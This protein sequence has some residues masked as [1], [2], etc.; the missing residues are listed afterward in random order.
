MERLL[1]YVWQHRLYP[2]G[3]LTTTAGQ[4]VEVL[5]PG[6]HNTDA[7]PDFLQAQ[8]RIG[9]VL[10]AGNVEIHLKSSDW[11][12]HRHES[13]PAYNNVV[14]HVVSQADRE[15]KTS[16]GM[17]LPQMIV[18]VPDYVKQ[19][20]EEL[21][22][23]ETFP[24]CYR[25]ATALPRLC[26]HSWLDALCT[27]RL[28]QKTERLLLLLKR[29]GG[30]WEHVCFVAIARA[31]GFGVNSEAFERWAV[32]LSMDDAACHRD[33]PL[34]TEALFM[35]MAGLLDEGAHRMHGH[36]EVLGDSYF[37]R[38]CLEYKS[39]GYEFELHP[40]PFEAW[41][42]L[43]LRPQNFPY[44]RLSQ[45]AGLFC[46]WRAT[47]SA[48][49]SAESL[50]ELRQCLKAECSPYWEEHYTFGRACRRSTHHLSPSSIDS[51]VINAVV[52]LL[53]AYGKQFAH[54]EYGQR[55]LDW[56]SQIK[57]EQNSVTRRW[58]EVGLTSRSAADSQA[59]LQLRKS[60]CDRRDCLRCRFGLEYLKKTRVYPFV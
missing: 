20:Y 44:L 24:P 50:D 6:V 7:G 17:Q 55:A 49:R 23:E 13:D 5:S 60:Y 56:L 36:E 28:E 59:L 27:E 14:L 43:R 46:S 3:R 34:V 15:V 35:G 18:E 9:E 10:W 58:C 52:P 38:L 47:L 37:C 40:I 32:A 45:L 31:F 51:L 39:L 2:T 8:I 48:L 25:N 19:N 26:R 42:F 1:H 22:H 21:L 33:N 11:E 53:F 29:L 12:A 41:R 30:D 4:P 16:A 54:P 57:P